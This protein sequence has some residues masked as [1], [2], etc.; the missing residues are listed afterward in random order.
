M[1]Y[2]GSKLLSGDMEWKIVGTLHEMEKEF[3]SRLT[4]ILMA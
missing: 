2:D 4:Q 1:A 3:N